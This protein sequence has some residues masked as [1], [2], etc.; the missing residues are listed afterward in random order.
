MICSHSC[1]GQP[2]T[3]SCRANVFDSVLDMLAGRYASDEFAELKPRITWDRISG[4]LDCTP[5]RAAHRDRQRRHDP[6]PR[7]VR[8]VSSVGRASW[9]APG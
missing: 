4:M 6:G 8:R 9:C 1:S 7:L 2:L 5:R 3:Q